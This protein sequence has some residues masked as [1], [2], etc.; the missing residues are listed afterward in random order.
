[1]TID[2]EPYFLSNKDWFYYDEEEFLIEKRGCCKKSKNEAY[3]STCKIKNKEYAQIEALSPP[4]VFSSRLSLHFPIKE[5]NKKNLLEC[6]YNPE[7]TL[8]NFHAFK[9][10]YSNAKLLNVN[11]FNDLKNKNVSEK[12]LKELRQMLDNY[13][14]D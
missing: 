10:K 4:S 7:E 9:R 11:C 13:E 3:I 2:K 12:E 8:D 6:L 1:M 14:K 5:L